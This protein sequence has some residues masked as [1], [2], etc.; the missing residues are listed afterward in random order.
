MK[1]ALSLE[2]FIS[3]S[4]Q[5]HGD[6]YDYSAV[7]ISGSKTL[8]S[9][10]CT[11]HG[12]FEQIPET[13]MKG[14]GC[15][16]CGQLI[17][18]EKRRLTKAKF[19][20]RSIA[21]HG[22]KYDYSR[23]VYLANDEKV[24]VTCPVHGL[25]SQ[26]PN[27]HMSGKGCILCAAKKRGEERQK[28][29][30]TSFAHR[31]RTVHGERYDYSQAT[32]EGA[33]K[34]IAIVCTAHGT[35]LQSPNNHLSGKGC[36]QCG[37]KS[38]VDQFR[39]NGE[40]FISEIKAVHGESFDYSLVNYIGAFEPVTLICENHGPI[41]KPAKEWL[42]YG[43]FLCGIE[44]RAKS[45]RFTHEKFISLAKEKHGEKYSYTNSNYE[46]MIEKIRIECHI[47]GEFWQTA[48]THLTGSGCPA[49][50]TFSGRL[51]D[52]ITQEDYIARCVAVHD[53]FY[54]YSNTFYRNSKELV[55]ITCPIHGEFTQ[56]AGNHLR[57]HGCSRCAGYGRTTEEFI[58]DARALHGERY[59]YSRVDFKSVDSN[60]L[61]ICPI[62]GSF[63]QRALGHL[64]G[65]G[66][67]GCQRDEWRLTQEEFVIRSNSVHQGKYD[68]SK[69]FYGKTNRDKVVIICP[70]HGS[71]EQMPVAHL[72]GHGCGECKAEGQRSTL[73]DFITSARL[74]H[75]NKYDYSNVDYARSNKNVIIKCPI[76]GEFLQT[77]STHLR[78][79]GCPKCNLVGP[80]TIKATLRGDYENTIGSGFRTL[81]V[82]LQLR[83]G[84]SSFIN[85]G[86]AKRGY[87]KRY[88]LNHPYLTTGNPDRLILPTQL[89]VLLEQVL[90]R[91]TA[92]Y[93][94]V[95][96][97]KFP[98]GATECRSLAA[99]PLIEEMVNDFSQSPAQLAES[100]WVEHEARRHGMLHL[101]NDLRARMVALA[102]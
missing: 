55:E 49:C 66:C 101:L 42:R 92:K 71:F 4:R 20:E 84:E 34:N 48:N 96:L 21:A 52:R 99:L 50:A 22:H 40:Q 57:G 102:G 89:A 80:Y 12:V 100:P 85:L 91:A 68:Y 14:F 51:K 36:P 83:E 69:A 1:A 30:A 81:Y 19:I 6:R 23:V 67:L 43:C 41:T 79:S 38:L 3:R 9:I 62:H 90:L 56:F 77:P 15:K 44:K 74:L 24:E 59:D 93:H 86:L 65:K 61:I 95:P 31:A 37:L 7:V 33:D 47:H 72:N 32:Y 73:E 63:E 28:A 76:H 88:S 5:A 27:S 94:Y 54:S 26:T 53:G 64:H 75:G 46:G 98:G 39:K 87:S 2:Q 60:V 11:V 78:G 58:A 17:A 70:I 10:R 82:A 13:H 97:V 45:K 16:A 29:A 35:F 8:V 18:S 25:F